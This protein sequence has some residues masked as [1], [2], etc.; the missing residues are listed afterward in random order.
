VSEKERAVILYQLFTLIVHGVEV[1]RIGGPWAR[2]ISK[3]PW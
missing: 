1:Q 3:V 2:Q